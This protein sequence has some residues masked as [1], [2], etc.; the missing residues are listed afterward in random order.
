MLQKSSLKRPL[1]RH[2][3]PVGAPGNQNE[4]KMDTKRLPKDVQK[5]RFFRIGRKTEKCKENILFTTL[6]LHRPHQKITI[7]GDFA[8][9][10]MTSKPRGDRMGPKCRQR[11][12]PKASR[13]GP[14][15]QIDPNR[16][17]NGLPRASQNEPKNGILGVL[18]HRREAKGLQGVSG[19]P[20]RFKM[21]PKSIKNGAKRRAK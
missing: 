16:V 13:T 9:P 11:A 1:V 14:E 12:P 15:P 19:H 18:G 6:Q 8:S 20:L 17:P 4:A 2:G 3:K 21:A 5:R 10:K 7:L